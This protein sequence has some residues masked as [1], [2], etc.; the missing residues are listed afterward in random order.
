MKLYKAAV[1]AFS[2][3]V[4]TFA[5]SSAQQND[6]R[7]P[8]IPYPTELIPASG[9]FVV[10]PATAIVAVASFK[11]EAAILNQLL[12]NSFGKKLKQSSAAA[13]K[14]ISLK[15]DGSVKADE[16]YKLTIN[17]K[18][19]VI[20]AKTAT[21]MFMGVQTLRQLLPAT[22]ERAGFK[23]ATSL[24][25]PAVTI[26]DAPVYAY[27]GMHLDVS[28]HFFSIGYL[29]KFIDIMS[30]Y[31]F[32]KFHLHLTDDQGWRVEIKKYPKLT[33]NGAWRTFNNQDTACMKRAADNPDFEIDKTH[34]IQKDGK[35]LYGGFY[36]QVQ[37]KELVAYAAARKIDIIPEIDM[38]G[39]M[40]A[41]INEYPYLSCDGT[42][43]EFGDLF[44]KPICPCLPSTFAFAQDVYSEIMDIFPSKYIHIGGDEVDRSLWGKSE[45]CKALMQKEGLKNTAELQSYFINN[46][47]KFFN[48]KG[49]KLIGWDEVLEGGIS[50]TAVI[51]YWR[52][53]VPKGPIE[54][55]KNGNKVIMT[56]GSP[57]YFDVPPDKN[58][59]PNVYNFEIIPKGL[60]DAEAKNI[61]G[62]Q[63]NIWTEYIPTENRADY[64]YMPRMTALAEVL[65]TH[66]QNYT[67]YLQRLKGQYSRLDILKVHYRLPDLTGFLFSNVFTDQ[68]ILDIKKPLPG[69]TVRY[70]TDG[71]LPNAGSTALTEP[72]TIKTSQRIR[73]AAFKAD[74][75]MGDAYDLQYQKQ[76]LAEPA[77]VQNI[78]KGLACSEYRQLYKNTS[79]IPTTKPDTIFTVQSITVPKEAE[80][81]SFAIKYRGYFDIPADGI[82]SF[83]LTCDDGGTLKIAGR[84][85]VNNDGLHAAIE[86]NGQV[87]LKKGLQPV[88]LDFIEGGGGYSLKLKYSVNGSEPKDIPSE[89]L[90]N[91]ASL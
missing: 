12:A 18:H 31:K 11:N 36:T 23:A 86:K 69:S 8:I 25:L 37:L 60:T 16:G 84:D 35:T 3:T 14:F 13:G 52:T 68:V 79:L 87:A 89:W 48:S 73:V 80:A 88:A 66:K 9:S 54:A 62:A 39:H 5:N 53:W 21:G 78:S 72:L 61:I 51:M 17:P 42:K 47:E 34:I 70:T 50:P 63:A 67:S 40:M 28:R 10:T 85:V 26:N 76:T 1:L 59:I 33:E 45:E 24:S 20:S 19:V 15:Y 6:A 83:Y 65:W 64:M 43:S 30:L 29:H 4:L 56:P 81:P 7:Y 57:L 75:S 32:N 49:R 2:I 41:A 71:S 82:Y 77:S 27:R 22:A 46:M 38:P 74:G 90:K 55:A 58:S 44:T 91:Q